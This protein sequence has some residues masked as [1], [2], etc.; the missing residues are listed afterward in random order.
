M[1]NLLNNIKIISVKKVFILISVLAFFA[2][3]ATAQSWKGILG[4]ISSKVSERT[5][6]ASSSDSSVLGNI[7]GNILGK[8]APL[9]DDVLEGLWGYQ[10]VACILESESA[11]ANI[12]GDAVATQ[13]EE[14]LDSYLIKVGVTKGSCSL[15]FSKD[16]SCVFKIKNRELKGSYKLNAE[17]KTVDFSF[18]S[19]KLCFK[20]YV[21][22]SLDCLNVVFEADKLLTLIKQT[23]ET[24]SNKSS[25]FSQSSELSAA[26]TTLGVVGKL[27][28]NYDGMMLGLELKK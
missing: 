23:L 28:E 13:I 3:S 25:S 24:V 27:L 22:W 9:N 6:V 11:L 2:C 20:T 21:S 26:G 10:G 12:G 7:L 14:K 4:K 17:E 5:S 18:M 1:Q 8:T 15:K 19:G 16:N